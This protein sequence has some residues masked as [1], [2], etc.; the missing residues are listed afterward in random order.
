MKNIIITAGPTNEKIDSVMKI[1]NMSTGSL[2]STIVDTL[3]EDKGD[4][5]E[6]I[7]FVSTK[8]TFKPK[9]ESDKIKYVTIESTQDLIDA[10]E[11]IFSTQ[12]ID[13]IIHSSAVGDY[14]GKYVIRTEELVDE[15]WDTI[16]EV[17]SREEI[18]KGKLMKIFENPRSICDND[19]KISSYEPH[20]M[21]MLQLT[22]KVI[23]KIKEMAPEVK[24]VGFKLLDGVTKEHL[25]EV[26][27]KLREKNDADYIVA[28]DLSKIGNGKHWAMIINKEGIV[29][30]CNTKKEIA[31]ALENVLFEK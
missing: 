16:Q 3:I 24:L 4:E 14:G 21:T 8:M 1:T 9:T 27:S 31:K 5:I 10:L 2:G 18:T 26:A 25:Y 20:L 19:T 23:G 7:Y 30:E 6:N 12:K 28:N 13:I 15:I 17:E 22:P 29:S 11:N